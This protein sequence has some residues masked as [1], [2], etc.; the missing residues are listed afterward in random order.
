MTTTTLVGSIVKFGARRAAT[1]DKIK[2]IVFEAHGSIE[3]LDFL[4]DKPLKITLEI[5]Q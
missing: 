3:N 2:T 1:G 4:M 5:T